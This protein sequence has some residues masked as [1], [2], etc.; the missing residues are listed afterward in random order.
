[1]TKNEWRSTRPGVDE[2]AP[3]YAA[4]VARVPDG[5]IVETLRNFG[6]TSRFLRAL[7]DS[8]GDHAY[9]EGKWS[10]KEVIGHMSDSERV[11]AYRA[12]RFSR[13][14]KIPLEGFDENE[15]VANSSFSQ[16]TLADLISEFEHLRHSTVLML[17]GISEAAMSNRGIANGLEISVRALA[18]ILAGHER[19]HVEI[20][21]TRYL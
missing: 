20:L 11:F 19:H 10:V 3:P 21:R 13:G 1:M 14:D 15:F 4:Y 5:D 12:L 2:F 9:A 17:D 18:F 16:R 8:I 6:E 7:P